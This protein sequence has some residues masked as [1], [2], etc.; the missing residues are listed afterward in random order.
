MKQRSD[1]EPV[2][3][4]SL[5]SDQE[6]F[7]PCCRRASD[8]P[9]PPPNRRPHRRFVCTHGRPWQPPWRLDVPCT[10]PLSA[11]Q[12]CPCSAAHSRWP[13]RSHAHTFARRRTRSR[14]RTVGLHRP[15]PWRFP[16]LGRVAHTCPG[17]AAHTC[18]RC[19]VHRDEP[20]R[21]HAH[22]P[23]TDEP[24]RLPA[25]ALRPPR[26]SASAAVRTPPCSSVACFHTVRRAH[27]STSLHDHCCRASV[28]D[29][30]R[31]GR[32]PARTTR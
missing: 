21:S 25:A 1:P 15:P 27:L 32:H 2:P 17:S 19:G 23:C 10:S 16:P 30:R 24:R 8:G 13:W 29:G 3:E 26:P 7:R 6:P 31:G 28:A 22:M 12:I 14:C 18:S 9:P 11:A 5:E 4:S 20:W